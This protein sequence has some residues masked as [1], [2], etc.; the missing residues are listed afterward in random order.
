MEVLVIVL[1]FFTFI[2]VVLLKIK[3]YFL[4]KRRENN[5]NIEF[6]VID[7][8]DEALRAPVTTQVSAKLSPELYNK[9]NEYCADKNVS[10]TSTINKAVE[11]YLQNMSNIT[12]TI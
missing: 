7:D 3:D 5:Y 10:K 6:E 11:I 12:T 4:N 2:A 9:L 8:D 1:I